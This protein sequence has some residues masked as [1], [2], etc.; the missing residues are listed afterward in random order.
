M[1]KKLNLIKDAPGEYIYQNEKE[2][3][4]C[5][6][7]IEGEMFVD[8]SKENRGGHFGHAMVEYADGKI[9][10]FYPSCNADN[11]GHSGRGWM[12]YKRS[13]DY[14][15]TWSE[16]IVLRHSYDTFKNSD[17]AFSVM[18][19]KAVMS[20]DGAI[21]LFCCNCDVKTLLP[22]HEIYPAHAALW[23]PYLKPTYLKS[24]D[25]G[26]SW[27][28]PFELCDYTARV[29]DAMVHNGKIYALVGGW[30]NRRFSL[31]IS[32]DGA[33]TFREG[34]VL[35]V[36]KWSFYGSLEI[37][38]DGAMIAYT[39]FDSNEPM[40]D[41]GIDEHN[42]PYCIS[43]DGGE[44]FGELRTAGFVKRLRNPQLVKFNSAYFMFG[45]SGNRG[46]DR[47]N[48]VC[49]CSKDGINWDEGRYLRMQDFPKKWG[50]C[51]YSNTLVVGRYNDDVPNRL[52][53]QA[54]VAY[55]APQRH[56]TNIMQWWFDAYT[57][58]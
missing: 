38:P 26:E 18:C 9:L 2:Y 31:Y 8:H 16:P 11:N 46:D 7:G 49:Y 28:G 1:A 42:L 52:Y 3:F 55:G 34:G 19:E 17:G 40:G 48:F 47:H 10:A 36:P 23:E 54:S 57:L 39:Y 14:G 29:Y 24:Y 13:E 27:E 12:E 35:P 50:V 20:D 37:L 56:L 44:S 30:D 43:Y 15:K 22:G 4:V 5:S 21:V 51:F 41:L 53:M 33:K 45:R 58:Q 25:G 32:E 6:T